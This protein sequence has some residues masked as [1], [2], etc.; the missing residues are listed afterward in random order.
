MRFKFFKLKNNKLFQN[1]TLH[2]SV[3]YIRVYQLM[4]YLLNRG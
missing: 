3:S 4:A 1:K 2:L